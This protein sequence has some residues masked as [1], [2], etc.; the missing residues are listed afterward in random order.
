L[1][2]DRAIVDIAWICQADR[3]EL[4][5]KAN[6]WADVRGGTRLGFTDPFT[7]GPLAVIALGIWT[8]VAW[9]LKSFWDH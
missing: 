6:A 9:R 3:W 4:S 1:T 7:I 5:A 8:I 2:T